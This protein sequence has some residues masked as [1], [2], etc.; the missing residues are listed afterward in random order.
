MFEEVDKFIERKKL[1]RSGAVIVVGV[2][3]G[4]DSMALLHY[5]SMKRKGWG[6]TIVAAHMD[7]MFRGEGS[8]EDAQFVKRYCQEHSI[9]FE[10]TRKNLPQYIQETGSSPQLASRKL[11]YQFY[12]GV[13]KAYQADYLALAHHGD[14]QIETMMMNIVR[15]TSAAGLSGIPLSRPFSTGMIIRPL[16][17]VT[18]D[19][20]LK[21]CD[22]HSVPFRNDPSNAESKYTRNRFRK[23]ILPFLKEE[24]THVHLK[25]QSLSEAVSEDEQYLRK[26]TED[27]LGNVILKKC[28]KELTLSV[29][30]FL[31]MAIPLQRRGIHLILNYLY[32][33]NQENIISNHIKDCLQLIKSENPS[34]EIHLPNGLFVRRSYEKCTFSFD[35]NDHHLP[36]RFALIEGEVH[37][38]P[39]G[40]L[41]F[42]PKSRMK[43]DK[44]GKDYL[45]FAPTQVNFPLFVRTRENGDRLQPAGVQGSRK[46]KDVFIDAKVPKHLRDV[47][48]IVVDSTG[49]II[50][51]PGIKHAELPPPT[52]AED[53]WMLLSFE[54]TRHEV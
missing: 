17:E 25:F 44:R 18:K 10:Q 3:G 16:L 22:V 31:K 2:S 42:L 13:M 14:D 6:L 50:W 8:V 1:V 43:T 11:R 30:P 53:D 19:Q 33:T 20:I 27:A 23:E 35:P 39:I 47:W 7:H 21:Y 46:V 40:K 51:I 5:L 24:N 41:T 32:P 48:P 28:D 36:Y 49:K 45:V 29:R 12:D 26:Q 52:G 9:E 15:G 37:Q 4:P 34:S 54:N 38:V